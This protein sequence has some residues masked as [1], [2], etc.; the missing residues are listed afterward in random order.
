MKLRLQLVKLLLRL[1][2]AIY[3]L[4]AS[5]ITKMHPL[6]AVPLCHLY[7][8]C[9]TGTLLPHLRCLPP[10]PPLPSRAAVHSTL[11]TQRAV[12]TEQKL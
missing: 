12:F 5:Y 7:P 6:H 1:G 9:H 11:C 8:A 2:S 10:C 3:P 4:L